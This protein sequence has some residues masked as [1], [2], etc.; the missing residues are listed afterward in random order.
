MVT[1]D[2]SEFFQLIFVS[3]GGSKKLGFHFTC[4]V[5]LYMLLK[6]FKSTTNQ[7][8]FQFFGEF[9][10]TCNLKYSQINSSAPSGQW[11]S[12]LFA[13]YFQLKCR[14]KQ[15]ERSQNDFHVGESACRWNNFYATRL[16]CIHH[17][18]LLPITTARFNDL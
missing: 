10:C 8:T 14:W 3:L 9:T 13:K 2:Y 17:H 18:M 15:L 16:T 12:S 4:M 5:L 6:F 7:F 1:P 11:C